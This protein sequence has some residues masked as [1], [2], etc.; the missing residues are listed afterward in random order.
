MDKV[1]GMVN[2]VTIV[3]NMT[4]VE[5]KDIDNFA[6]KMDQNGLESNRS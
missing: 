5:S 4:V 1:V 2:M 6:G 3:D